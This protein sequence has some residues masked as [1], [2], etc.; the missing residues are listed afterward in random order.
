MSHPSTQIKDHLI[1]PL[2]HVQHKT[3]PDF[4]LLNWIMTNCQETEV[5]EWRKLAA[6]TK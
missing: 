4:K 6:H 2:R 3:V 1:F 5:E